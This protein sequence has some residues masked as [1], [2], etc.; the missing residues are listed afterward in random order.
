MGAT[1]GQEFE[2]DAARPSKEVEGRGCFS[3]EVN[4][5][6]QDIEKSVVGRA[7]KVRGTS[8]WRP[9]YLPATTLTA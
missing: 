3:L 2:G 7:L 5:G 9:R 8:K 6:P 4:I 1:S